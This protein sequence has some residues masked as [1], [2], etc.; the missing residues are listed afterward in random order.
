MYR[1]SGKQQDK[2]ILWGAPGSLWSG[3]TRAYF[4]KKG[5]EYQE[6]FPSHP[7]FLQEVTPLVGIWRFLS[8]S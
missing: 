1:N 8:M 2:V 6:I 5:I 3:R 4:I 7:R